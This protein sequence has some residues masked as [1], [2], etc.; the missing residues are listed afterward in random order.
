MKIY[1]WKESEKILI[2]NNE[3][4]DS[5]QKDSSLLWIQSVN[6]HEQ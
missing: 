2:Y 5:S 4:K 3:A 1:K 6:W